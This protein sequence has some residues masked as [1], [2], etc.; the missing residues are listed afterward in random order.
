VV[1]IAVGQLLIFLGLLFN[2]MWVR[3]ACIGGIIFGLAI[4]PL[5]VG[6]AFP[7][8]ISMAVSFFILL[9]KYEHDLIWKWKQYQP[10]N[11]RTCV[12]TKKVDADLFRYT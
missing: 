7:A 11:K 9:K 10:L 2:K 1:S 4:G 6:S 8:T 12:N 3:L 5:G